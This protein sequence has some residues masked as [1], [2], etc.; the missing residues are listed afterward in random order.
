MFCP[1]LIS[2]GLNPCQIS[3]EHDGL[4]DENLCK[5]FESLHT[6]AHPICY[7]T[8]KANEYIKIE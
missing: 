7:V 8:L 6:H 3:G 4:V 2:A 1:H 5:L